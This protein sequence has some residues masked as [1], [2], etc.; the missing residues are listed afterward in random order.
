MGQSKFYALQSLTTTD[1]RLRYA[2]A[3]KN[4]LHLKFEMSEYL[5]SQF[6]LQN[7]ELETL[8]YQFSA[9]SLGLRI[10]NYIETRDSRL[11]VLTSDDE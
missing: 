7:P 3:I 6:D 10:W 4:K 11:G 8:N 2:N 9:A 5:R 1:L